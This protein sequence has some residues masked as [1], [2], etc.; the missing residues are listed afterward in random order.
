MLFFTSFIFATFKRVPEGRE[1]RMTWSVHS[2]LKVCVIGWLITEPCFGHCLLCDVYLIHTTFQAPTLLL[3]SGHRLSLYWQLCVS[4][5]VTFKGQSKSV[6]KLW[7][8]LHFL[9]IFRFGKV[10]SRLIQRNIIQLNCVVR[11]C[12]MLFRTCVACWSSHWMNSLQ[13]LPIWSLLDL[14][15]L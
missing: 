7:L 6:Q 4:V 12:H 15:H 2:S 10:S 11:S 14:S 5:I 1:D 13:H 3:S 8:V 9:F